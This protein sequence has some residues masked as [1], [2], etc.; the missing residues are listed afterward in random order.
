M[1]A[2]SS[3]C[4]VFHVVV[5]QSC[6]VVTVTIV[7]NDSHFWMVMKNLTC[8]E[9]GNKIDGCTTLGGTCTFCRCPFLYI[10]I[11]IHESWRILQF[12][13]TYLSHYLQCH[14]PFSMTGAFQSAL[15]R[16]VLSQD[17]V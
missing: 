13:C 14:C 2:T 1:P 7:G 4:L 11:S 16:A 3:Y 15:Q 8:S 9:G 17:P 10:F 6:V 5:T 12:D